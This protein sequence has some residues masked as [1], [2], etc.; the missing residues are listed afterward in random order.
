MIRNSLTLFSFIMV[1]EWG[2][3]DGGLVKNSSIYLR[4]W[5]MES[6]RNREGSFTSW[7][8]PQLSSMAVGSWKPGALYRSVTLAS[9]TKSLEP[10]LL[11]RRLCIAG[12][13]S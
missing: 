11:T 5:E 10:L 2:L 3:R 7:F 13:C 8:T 1:T 6:E 9:G 12:C 4:S